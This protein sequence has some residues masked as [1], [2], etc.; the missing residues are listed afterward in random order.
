MIIRLRILKLN[1]PQRVVKTYKIFKLNCAENDFGSSTHTLWLS[2]QITH[3][4]CTQ[5]K[6]ELTQRVSTLYIQKGRNVVKKIRNSLRT[7]KF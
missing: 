2:N 3:T 4:P 1:K 6:K 7:I 5:K